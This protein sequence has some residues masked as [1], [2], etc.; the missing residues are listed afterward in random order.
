M[1]FKHITLIDYL[2][3]TILILL[4]FVSLLIFI[5]N[6]ETPWTHFS[7][8]TKSFLSGKLNLT[9]LTFDQHNYVIKNGK[10]YW[11][12]GPFPSIILIPLQVVIGPRFNQGLMQLIL[13]IILSI[14]LFKLA[15]IKKYNILDSYFLV[16]VFLLGSPLVGIVIDPKSW[17]FAQ[18]VSVTILTLLL[19]ELETKRRWFVIGILEAALIATRPTSATIILSLLYLIF[20]KG[21]SRNNKLNNLLSLLTPVSVCVI[22]LMVFNQ[23]RFGNALDNG[24]ATNDVGGYLAPIRDLGLFSINHIPS[25]IYYY[26]LSSVEAVQSNISMHLTF[27][28]MKYSP[29]GLSVF[30]VAPFFLYTFKSLKSNCTYTKALWISVAVTQFILLVYFAPGWVQFGP[31]YTADYFPIL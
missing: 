18:I 12:E 22:L 23:L 9:P 7:D 1:H 20:K 14:S 31:R 4:Q 21:T 13:L 25:N 2:I 6:F 19:L 27:P 29:W 28:F 17:F 11:P 30:L 15:R 26:F 24:Y 5:S 10:Y 3:I 8:Q 16:S